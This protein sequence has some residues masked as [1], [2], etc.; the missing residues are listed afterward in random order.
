MPQERTE[1]VDEFNG[2]AY[3][4]KEDRIFVTGKWWPKLFEIKVKR[5]NI[6]VSK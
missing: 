4:E 3:D 2:I 5:P 1:K 6:A